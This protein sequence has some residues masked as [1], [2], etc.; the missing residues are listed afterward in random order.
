M[1][2]LKSYFSPTMV[3][4]GFHCCTQAFS[5]CSDGGGI[6][7]RG[8]LA[9]HC[10]GLLS[11]SAG[12]SRC[13]PGPPWLWLEGLEGVESRAWARLL[14]LPAACG[15]F[16]TRDRTHVLCAGRRVLIHRIAREC[17][18]MKYSPRPAATSPEILL[19]RNVLQ[20]QPRSAESNS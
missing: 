3:A 15:I 19:E 9:S 1:I 4:L 7:R 6:F 13:C 2:F 17:G 16:Q 18:A 12:I 14:F 10:R 20:P 5:C 11:R 8:A